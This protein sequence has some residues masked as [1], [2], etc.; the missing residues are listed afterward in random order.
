MRWLNGDE[1][2]NGYFVRVPHDVASPGLV[3]FSPLPAARTV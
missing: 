1:T 3:R 2:L